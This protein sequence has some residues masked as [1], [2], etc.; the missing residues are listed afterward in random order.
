MLF[1]LLVA[2]CEHNGSHTTVVICTVGVRTSPWRAVSARILAQLLERSNSKKY[3]FTVLHWNCIHKR[4]RDRQEK[5]KVPQYAL[6]SIAVK[7]NL[8][9]CPYLLVIILQNCIINAC[10]INVIIISALLNF[11]WESAYIHYA[12]YETLKLQ[13]TSLI[14]P[15]IYLLNYPTISY[16]RPCKSSTF[17]DMH[18]DILFMQQ[19]RAKRQ[20]VH[21]ITT[22]LFQR[23]P[24]QP[25]DGTKR[26]EGGKKEKWKK[27]CRSWEA[28]F[29]LLL[30]ETAH[31]S[32]AQ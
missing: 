6:L 2:T 27:Q 25:R 16:L 9:Y 18:D 4:K 7:K 23:E 22:P 31:S 10:S 14:R 12:V 29:F 30:R 17:E 1:E 21:K 13:W 32:W 8:P 28:I 5:W 19:V 11:V 3:T 24:N 26:V 20:P 15:S